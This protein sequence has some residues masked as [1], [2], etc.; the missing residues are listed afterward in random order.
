LFKITELVDVINVLQNEGELGLAKEFFTQ[1]REA[2]DSVP[3][4]RLNLAHI[5]L[6]QGKFG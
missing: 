6:A 4:V 2:A 3:D 1:V 5:H